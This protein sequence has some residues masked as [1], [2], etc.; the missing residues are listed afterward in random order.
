M[1]NR[2]TQL[3]GNIRVF[4][5]VRPT[6]PGEEERLK[7]IESNKPKRNKKAPASAASS[8]SPFHFPGALDPSSTDYDITKRMVEI[9]E[10][11]KDRG[12]LSE[13]R[14]QWRYPF[15]AVFSPEH[16]Q[17]DV[18]E[19]TSPLVQSAID[20]FPVCIFAYG[21]TGSGKTYTM[22]GEAG[23]EGVI[24]RSVDKMFAAKREL[25]EFSR[26]TTK[27]EMSIELLEIYNEQVRDLLAPNAGPN[28][29]EVALKVT[30]NEVVGNLRVP[31]GSEQE[32]MDVL[33]LAQS[34]RC[35]KATQSN[36]E[37]SRSH[38]VFT[39]HFSVTMKNGVKRS[40]KLNICDLAG[41]E[42]L[43]KSGANS[44]VKVCDPFAL[45][46]HYRII[47]HNLTI[48]F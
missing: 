39:L 37:S 43:S 19:A 3:S 32:V 24:A 28:G 13:R 14:K 1:H 16:N 15:D 42:R 10:P 46:V 25:E 7:A 6:I 18:W 30:S 48:A 17:N 11:A 20:G 36:A 4:V 44:I 38:M 9:L 8:E 47:F 40:G 31:A 23:N 21:Q 45:V 22:L 35:V 27:V 29:R 33:A 5:R 34:R 12:G 41:S 26:G 2:V